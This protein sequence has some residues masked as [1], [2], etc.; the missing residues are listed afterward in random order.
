MAI[1]IIIGVGIVANPITVCILPFA[2]VERECIIDII[3]AIIVIIIIVFVGDAISI[4]VI[5]LKRIT[6]TVT[7]GIGRHGGRINRIRAAISLIRIGPTIVVVVEVLSQGRGRSED[8]IVEIDGLRGAVRRE[9][10]FQ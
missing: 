9:L 10:N 2:G 8:D 4:G 3:D 1:I 6:D 7:I 5:A